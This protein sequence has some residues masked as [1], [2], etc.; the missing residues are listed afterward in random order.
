MPEAIIDVVGR[1]PETVTL[2][3]L[4]VV[5][6]CF[7]VF[8]VIKGSR[9]RTALR[10]FGYARAIDEQRFHQLEASLRNI[11]FY[12]EDA[13]STVHFEGI[14]EE[15]TGPLKQKICY[16]TSSSDDPILN[17]KNP[18]ILP[19]YIGE[20]MQRTS[21]FMNLKANVFVMTMPDLETFHIKRSKVSYF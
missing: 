16:L 11:V 5:M 15:L 12:A 7:L 4:V 17:T 19:F 21:L 10:E 2:L 8:A 3:I 18:N 1:G 9:A 13:P 20:G 14:I 6:L